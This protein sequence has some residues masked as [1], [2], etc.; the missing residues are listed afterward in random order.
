MEGYWLTHFETGKSSGNGVAM[1][2]GGELLGGDSEH[3][4]NGTYE[5]DGWRI[6]A[7]IRIVPIMS[8]PQEGVMARDQPMIL[9]LT[10]L[11]TE[12]YAHLEG[13]AEQRADLHFRITMH[14]CTGQ[15]PSCPSIPSGSYVENM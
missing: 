8:S 6:Y 15:A 13:D 5:E 9:T 1:L 10:G 4:W 11:C 3:Q 2:H 12:E 14:K 7:R